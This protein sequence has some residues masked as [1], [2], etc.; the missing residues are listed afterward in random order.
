MAGQMGREQLPVRKEGCQCQL[1]QSK[2]DVPMTSPDNSSILR[3]VRCYATDEAQP[4]LLNTMKLQAPALPQLFQAFTK[5]KKMRIKPVIQECLELFTIKV[6]PW[7]H[8]TFIIDLEERGHFLGAVIYPDKI[9][10]EV[11]EPDSID[12]VGRVWSKGTWISVVLLLSI[13]VFNRLQ[14]L[15]STSM[16]LIKHRNNWV[17]DC[18]YSEHVQTKKVIIL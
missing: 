11:S 14:Y 10:G 17:G 16:E 9:L 7:A 12:V 6:N 18:I 3:I 8:F 15:C 13:K 2:E 5:K 4:W 1:V